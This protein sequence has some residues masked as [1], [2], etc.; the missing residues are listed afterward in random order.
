MTLP[1]G[2]QLSPYFGGDAPISPLM[3][4]PDRSVISDH[5]YCFRSPQSHN[6]ELFD[7]RPPFSLFALPTER[8]QG[9]I[10]LA[11]LWAASTS[12]A[13]IAPKISQHLGHILGNVVLK[14]GVQPDAF[15]QP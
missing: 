15:L 5:C 12:R 4:L 1:M 7:V 9:S 2:H 13:S 6:L 14:E 8:P 11:P 10:M 3:Q